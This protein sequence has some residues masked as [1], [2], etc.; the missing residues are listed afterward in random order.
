M[1]RDPFGPP[2]R[3]KKTIDFS[4]LLVASLL[5]FPALGFCQDPNQAV[6]IEDNGLTLNLFPGARPAGLAGAYT[7]I[8]GDVHSLVYNPA[9]L[10]ATKRIELSLGFANDRY[11]NGIAFYGSA[12]N[13]ADRSTTNLDYVSV[14]YPF[15]TYRGSLV[16]AF[17]IYRVFSSDMDLI[18]SGFN[19][20]SETL[21][22]YALQQSG[23]V[24]SYNFGFGV[25]LSPSLSG[26][27]SF[28]VL[29]GNLNALTQFSYAYPEPI[30]QGALSKVFVDDDV[31]ADL[32]GYGGRLGIQ[33]KPHRML[34]FGISVT[35]PTWIQLSGTA[36]TNEI[37]YYEN[38]TSST[39]ED[40]YVLAETKYRLP[41]Q[42][43]AGVCFRPNEILLASL[44]A[45]YAD[46]T[47]TTINKVQLRGPSE[48][49]EPTVRSAVFRQVFNIRTGVEVTIPGVPVR[50]RGGYAYLPYP[51]K[52]L[53]ADRI[54][55]EDLRPADVDT[56]RQLISL[57]AGGLVG[58]VLALDGAFVYTT[59]ERSIEPV[60]YQKTSKSFLL[61]ASYRF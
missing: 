48:P 24:F 18:Y 7:A 36:D 34:D 57:G 32:D 12:K 3:R 55:N 14:A 42:I 30:S 53:Q 9:G 17:G 11:K 51:L 21:D 54:T 15:P 59:G 45:G 37:Y 20:D 22:K 4:A 44:D 61:S 60:I 52:Q 33:F 1:K 19:T 23:S 10:A 50:F 40:H 41:F 5:L 43:D 38:D 8:G 46:W 39:Y 25:D 26:G 56:E 13:E 2:R 35:T 16:G 49:G 31:D 27:A 47:Q 6:D 29:D 58:K 28:F